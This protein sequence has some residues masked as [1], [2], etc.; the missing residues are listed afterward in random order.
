MD[1]TPNLLLNSLSQDLPWG[2][3]VGLFFA[4]FVKFGIAAAAAM[5]NK[6]LNFVEI[7]L[8]IGGGALVSVPFYT[9]FGDAIRRWFKKIFPKRKPASFAKRRRIYTIWKRYGLTGVAFL[10]PVISPMIAVGIAVAFQESPRRI[11]T[12]VGTAVATWSF[13]FAFLRKWVLMALDFV[14]Y[15]V[16]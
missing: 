15:Q 3:Y 16:F 11:I 2:M 12:Y 8:T 7:L 13:I 10:S 5:A 14:Q 6:S 4:S 1:W 9:F